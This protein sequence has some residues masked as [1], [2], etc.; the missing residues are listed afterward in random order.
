MIRQLN[1]TDARATYNFL[2]RHGLRDVFLAGKVHEG[3]RSLPDGAAQGRFLGAFDGERL[4]GVLFLGT[5]G[6]IVFASELPHVRRRFAEEAWRERARVRLIV[7]E[8]D[9]VSDFWG[10]LSTTGLTA[11]RDWREVFMVCD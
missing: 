8:W 5:G 11:A 4:D 2:T 10:H 9:Q 1:A 7:G 6:L 3:A